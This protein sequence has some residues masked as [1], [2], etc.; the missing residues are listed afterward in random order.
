MTEEEYEIHPL[1]RDYSQPTSVP[2]AKPLDLPSRIRRTGIAVF[3]AGFLLLLAA[4]I[5]LSNVRGGPL[6]TIGSYAHQ[7]SMLMILAGG[8]VI[9]L[10]YRWNQIMR[11]TPREKSMRQWRRTKWFTT[12]VFWNVVA[13]AVLGIV[14]HLSRFAISSAWTSWIFQMTLTI[15]C[16]MMVTTVVVN[17]GLLRAYAIGVAVAL[18]MHGYTSMMMLYGFMPRRGQFGGGQLPWTYMI[19]SAAVVVVSGLA[20]ALYACILD[21]FNERRQR[22][23]SENPT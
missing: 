11:Y 10:S 21:Y 8:I 3:A 16:A 18:I 13:L 4:A 6:E 5:V 1:D 20:C 17:R 7:F 9:V 2:K 22:F 12:L 15:L 14:I 19:A 23:D